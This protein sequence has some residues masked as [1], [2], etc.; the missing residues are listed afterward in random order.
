MTLGE[1][2]TINVYFNKSQFDSSIAFVTVN[3]VKLMS[4]AYTL[5]NIGGVEYYTYKITSITPAN[6]C[7]EIMIKISYLGGDTTSFAASPVNYLENLL[8]YLLH[9]NLSLFHHCFR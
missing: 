5:V 4:N 3:S 1:D 6:A 8:A 9:P 7:D 2:I